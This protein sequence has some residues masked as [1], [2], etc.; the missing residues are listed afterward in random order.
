MKHVAA[1]RKQLGVPTIFNLLGPLCNPA[2]APYQL[3]GVVRP[4][5]RNLLASALSK[6]GTTRS[7]VVCGADGLDEVTTDGETNVT[8]VVGSATDE[9]TW[10]PISLACKDHQRNRC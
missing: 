6:L 9:T 10:S 5:I 7:A 2:K 3:L 1:V 4:D 8:K